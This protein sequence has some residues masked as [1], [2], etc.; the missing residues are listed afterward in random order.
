VV[1]VVVPVVVDVETVLVEV[2]DVDTIAVRGDV[3]CPSSSVAP[4]VEVYRSRAYILSFLYFIREQAN[5]CYLR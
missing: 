3:V 1:A 5:N 4:E 2:A